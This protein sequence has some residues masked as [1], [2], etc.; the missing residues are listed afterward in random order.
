MFNAKL[1]RDKL[2]LSVQMLTPDLAD[3]LNLP[4]TEGLL[5]AG[6]DRDSPASAVG[7]RR[8][9][10]ILAVDGQAPDNLIAAARILYGKKKGEKVPLDILVQRQE[11]VFLI[12]QRVSVELATR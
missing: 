4:S 9:H 3:Q 7:L 5:I 10:V 8:G 1:I 12:H 11:G 6:V 2:G